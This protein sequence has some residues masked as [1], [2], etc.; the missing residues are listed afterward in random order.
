LL[1][2]CIRVCAPWPNQCVPLGANSNISIAA[3]F[4]TRLGGPVHLHQYQV[5]EH[6]CCLGCCADCLALRQ[7]GD[8]VYGYIADCMGFVFVCL[9]V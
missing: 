5:E 6:T 8:C 9:S 7:H 2:D 3:S 1:L 4:H